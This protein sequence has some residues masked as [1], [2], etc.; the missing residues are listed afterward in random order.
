ME[1]DFYF[2]TAFC[3]LVIFSNASTA[4]DTL[5]QSDSLTDGMTLVSGD[6][7]FQLGFFS[8]GSSKNRYL[9]IWYN[10]IPMQ[11]VVWV[12]NRVNPINDSTGLLKIQS[13]GKIL[14]LVQNT[15]AVWCANSTA[16]VENPVLQL[17]DSGNL[18]VRDGKDSEPENYLWQSFD[19][20]SDIMLPGMKIGI[21]LR[22]GLHRRL[23]AW[24]NWDDPSPGDLTYG[25]ELEGTPEMVLRKG[26]E[27]YYRSGLWNGDGFSGTPNLRSNP[28]F[29]YDFVWNEN[30]VY[31]IYS[32]KNKSVMSRFVL[33]QTQSVRQRYTWNPETQTWKLFSIM[34]SDLCDRSGLCGPNGDCDNNKL[35]ACQCLT[36]FRPKWLER[37]NSSD[38]SDGCIH[39]KPLNCKSG[40]GFIRIGKVKTPDTINSWVNKTMNLKECRAKCL[41]NCS[42]MA[43]TNLYV[44]RGGSG[45]AMWYGDLLDIKQFQSDGQDLY[46]RVSAS[47]AERKKKAKVK[48]AI[49]L[50]T[51][52]AAILGFLLIVCYI[53]RSRRKLKDEVKDKNL[54][55]REDK[56]ENEDMEL[57]VFEFGTIAQATDSFSFNNK[58]GQGGFGPV[59][60]GTLGNGQ[61]IA[62]KRLS[63]SSGQGLH[64]F[65]NEVKLIA[66]LQHRNLVRLLGCCI[67]GDERML[68]YEYMPN[69]SLD[70]FIFDQTRR[71]VLS[72]SKRFRIICGIARG[73]L[74]LHQDSRLRIIHR[75]LKTS[76]VL[77]DSEMNPKISDFGLA[78]T[79]GG[80]QTEA[81]TNR[82][83][84][85]YG[86]MAPEYAID[87]LFS[88]KSDVFSFGILLLEIIS[89]RKNRGFYHV[90]QSGNLI[91]HAWRLWKE[92]KPLDLADDFLADTGD[93]SELL[94]C[95]HVS[96]LCIQQHPEERPNMSSV[97]LMLGSHNELPSPKQPGFLFYNKPFEAD[98]SSGNDRLSSRNEISLSL[99]EAR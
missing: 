84:G 28:I 52:I 93:L 79:F 89:G 61:E 35:P 47:E 8:P 34:P 14:L 6:G 66:K 78:R 65:K 87:G 75:D 96:L 24:K 9:G 19:Y 95:I 44:T 72:W 50:G 16:R 17:L 23:A 20:P 25:V 53:L 55:D 45:C 59:Y 76:N 37:W 21:D 77:L 74:Y 68:V 38:W 82:V 88:V 29:D 60:K 36:G 31:Y 85:T 80:D 48:L 7:S 58:L 42:C 30:E 98:C 32:L 10:N 86:Y 27:K 83:V 62:V 92:S 63:K 54:N 64:E 51:V 70:S 49:I 26:S 33:N 56:D 39:S 94:R 4:I 3:F 1:M 90:N 22:T 91:E 81:N 13:N 69:R 73:L 18:V 71:R 2:Y 57:A 43:Y 5:S 67:H 97:V 11:T 99:L 46:I 12:A 41:R 40:D 15:T